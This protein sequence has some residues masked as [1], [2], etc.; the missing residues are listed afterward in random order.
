MGSA[1]GKQTCLLCGSELPSGSPDGWCPRCALEQTLTVGA[2]K[3]GNLSLELRDIPKP[4]TRISYIG[5]Y[6]VLGLI[7][8]GGMGVVYKA[9]QRNL[10]RTVALKL[11]L[12]GA[13]A[14]EPYKLRFRHEAEMAAKM[15]HP[16][17]V[18]IYEVGEHEGQ[19]FFAMEYV[20]GPNLSA[21]VSEQPLHSEK[22]AEYIKTVAEAIAYAHGQGVLHRDIKPSNILLGNDGRPRITDFGLARQ[23]DADSRLTLSGEMLGT[24]GYLPPEQVSVKA[25]SM[26]PQSDVYSL[27]AVLYFLL[28]G[29]PPFVTGTL[30][31]TLEQVLRSEPASLRQLNPTISRDL[32]N[33]CLKCLQ[34]DVKRR[35]ASMEALAD[36]LRRY[37]AGETV[38]ARP[39]S[40]LERT[41][42]WV[43]RH[44]L[45]AGLSSALALILIASVAGIT[46]QWLRAQHQAQK[47]R[48]ALKSIQIESEKVK[49][50]LNEAE[51]Q[52]RRA[53]QEKDIAVTARKS[54]DELLRHLLLRNDGVVLGD[55]KTI[56]IDGLDFHFTFDQNIQAILDSELDRSMAEFQPASEVGIVVNPKTGDILAIANKPGL[57][58]N[59]PNP[60]LG[61][62]REPGGLISFVIG[63][64]A[65]N[66]G[67]VTIDSAFDRENGRFYYAGHI[68]HDFET[69]GMIR[70]RE[71]I[72]RHSDI[73]LAKLGIMLGDKGLSDCL[74]DFGF[75]RPTGIHL[76]GEGR[77]IVKPVAQWT[78][79]TKAHLPTGYGLAVTPLQIIMA[80]AAIANEG[81]LMIPRVIQ[82]VKTA[83]GQEVISSSPE[84][85][86]QVISKET[87]ALV[88]SALS[89]VA[90]EHGMAPLAGVNGFTV[91]GVVTTIQKVV[92][93]RYS[94]E[95][96]E[97]AFLGFLPAENPEF[98]CL[99]IM[100]DP[101]TNKRGSQ[102]AAPVFSRA[103]QRIATY[104]NLK[105]SGEV[106]K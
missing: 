103:S 8:R 7:A 60:A 75:G 37:M 47:T 17:I 82:S 1:S 42:K 36:D 52:S 38:V 18:P 56:L 10:R 19:P 73:G 100:D 91:G 34:K 55:R 16:N 21:L 63:A 101:K 51:V 80:M 22:A 20:S 77:G 32:E 87:A 90:G 61:Y 95:H 97:S 5:D 41:T 49:T 94:T 104:L 48:A 31:D 15:Q 70:V 2:E 78:K 43:Q 39:V 72:A 64:A 29:R 30:T 105:S 27:G 92:D 98:V 4:G 69:N 86:K 102:T 46:S 65:L 74:R 62:I 76:P 11:L 99:I 81:K 35:Y 26:G 83:D 28:T 84:V 54:A 93:G 45:T 44:P 106:K 57:K 25:G 58:T 3:L 12:G 13:H 89:D 6:E 40:R 50:A 68:I 71:I 9:C 79:I 53:N 33:I 23:M 14:S 88:K 96:F 67:I 66:I 24:P 85:A 59:S